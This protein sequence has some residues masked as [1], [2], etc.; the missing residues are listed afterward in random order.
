MPVGRVLATQQ[1][2]DAAK[3]L[4]ALT[5]PV[6]EQVRRVLQHGGILADPYHWDCG[7]A[8]TWR[9][10]WG[11][12]AN[13]L[14][15]AAAKLDELEHTAQQV[16][17]DIFKADGAPGPASVGVLLT[18]DE[19]VFEVGAL[20]AALELANA[21]IF[22]QFFGLSDPSRVHDW[23]LT[24]TQEERDAIIAAYPA[25]VG[26]LDGIPGV[27]RDKANRIVVQQQ[28][29]AVN[30]QRDA[31]NAQR[32]AVNAQ[33]QDLAAHEPPRYLGVGIENP[34]WYAWHDKMSAL[35]AHHA[36]LDDQLKGL[37]D[38]LKGL[39]KIDDRLNHAKSDQ[40]PA[41]LLGVDTEGKG[42]AIIAIN[43]P[44]TADNVITYVPGLDSRLGSIGADINRSGE[45]VK[46]ANFASGYAQST[47][48][49][50]WV[51]Y[52]APQSFLS[53]TQDDYARDAET[54]LRNFETGLR[55][56]H[57]GAPS[58]NTII[59]HSYGSTTVGF[60]MR[61]KGLPVD[62][63]I[64]VG[65]PGVGVEHAYDLGVDPS[66]VYVGL[67]QNDP[68][69][70]SP[71]GSV[72]GALSNIGN[73]VGDW[74]GVNDNPDHHNVFGRN[75]AVPQ[76]GANYLPA[77]PGKDLLS[78]KAHSQYWDPGSASLIAIGQVAVGQQP[79]G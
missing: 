26:E 72:G 42:H 57:E 20:G 66:H 40:P 25:M 11:R 54:R 46:S 71:P 48:S 69:R 1:A 67:A 3:Q 18:T 22:S 10:D 59:G 9:N 43:N 60:A 19:S 24:H 21:Q 23:W 28:L 17:E 74:V 45:M 13:Q 7:L 36:L 6:K 38:Q 79:H 49:I 70:L 65:S 2:R 75:P 15:Q 77:D 34:D 31:V 73:N 64:F 50:T 68:I 39:S 61:D 37:N 12:D 35:S 41:F 30:A 47:S 56:T 4:L 14:N 16:V 33:R 76:F 5:G 78:R 32:D 62:N 52:D 8:G 58:R 53:A 27:D 55:T 63:V 29:D 51:G 44:D